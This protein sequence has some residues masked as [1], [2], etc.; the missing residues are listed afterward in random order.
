MPFLAPVN[1]EWALNV[2]PQTFIISA[3]D[4]RYAL[5]LSEHPPTFVYS[6]SF[7]RR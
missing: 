6:V 4:T 5:C 7:W 3:Y 1:F 2:L